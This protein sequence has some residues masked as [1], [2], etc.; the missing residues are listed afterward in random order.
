ML[1]YDFKNKMKTRYLP[2]A[3]AFCLLFASFICLA[4]PVGPA[5]AKSASA[6]S[7]TASN[8]SVVLNEFTASTPLQNGIEVRSG[9]AIMKITALR[10]DVLR[11]R[12]ASTGEMPEDASWAV[13]DSAR[14][15]SASVSQENS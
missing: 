9:R 15:Q 5:S 6:K 3:A 11:I 13:L 1:S 10:D 12:I 2:P 7:K 8:T 14:Q 4:D